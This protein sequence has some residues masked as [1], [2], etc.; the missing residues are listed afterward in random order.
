MGA[1]KYIQKSIRTSRKE[2]SEGYRK[3]MSEKR[4]AGSVVK[5]ERPYNLPSARKFGYKATKGFVVAQ[6]KM[7]KGRRK[8]PKPSGGRSARHNYRFTPPSTSHQAIAERKA[9]RKFINCEVLGSYLF[10]EDGQYKY[11]EI[12]LADR[13]KKTSKSTTTSRKGRAFRGLTSAGKKGRYRMKTAKN[14]KK[15]N[16][17][18]V[19]KKRMRSPTTLENK[20]KKGK[21][22]KDKFKS[23]NKDRRKEK[24][25]KKSIA[26]KGKSK[27]E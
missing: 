13:D 27:K 23:K 12:I 11:F 6:V 2:R 20:I 21:G 25:A 4:R 8:R 18:G 17:R 7:K 9:S 16:T 3:T 10:G 24:R 1:Y 22:T 5:S 26:K 19:R 15:K 14:S